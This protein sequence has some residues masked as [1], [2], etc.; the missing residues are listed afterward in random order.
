MNLCELPGF[1]TTSRDHGNS[2][3]L[4]HVSLKVQQATDLLVPLEQVSFP[5]ISKKLYLISEWKRQFNV[6]I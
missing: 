3:S 1:L 6:K 4:N 2:I 5:E